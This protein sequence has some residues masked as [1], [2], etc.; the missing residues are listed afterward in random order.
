[1]L[2]RKL[3]EDDLN[4]PHLGIGGGAWSTQLAGLGVQNGWTPE[5]T[6]FSGSS[7]ILQRAGPWMVR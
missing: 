7:S 4:S 6:H 2:A 1:M 5:A 3:K